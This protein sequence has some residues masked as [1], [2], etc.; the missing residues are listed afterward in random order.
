MVSLEA[1]GAHGRSGR[2]G[3]RPATRGGGSGVWVRGLVAPVGLGTAGPRGG[4]LRPR[5]VRC[6]V[7]LVTHVLLPTSC[8]LRRADGVAVVGAGLTLKAAGRGHRPV[9]AVVGVPAATVRRWFAGASA[10]LTSV[11][12]LVWA[13]LD[14]LRT[15]L[16]VWSPARSSWSA[17]WARR[18]GAGSGWSARCRRGRWSQRSPGAGCRRP[19]RRTGPASGSTRVGSWS[20]LADRRAWP[21]DRR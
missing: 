20:A 10:A 15:P 1:P 19:R 11:L 13:E 8:L 2:G 6:A 7:C 3:G 17:W 5:R 9:A 16:P 12:A 18:P 21:G 4:G 14:P